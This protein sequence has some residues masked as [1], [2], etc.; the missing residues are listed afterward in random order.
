MRLFEARKHLVRRFSDVVGKPG[1]IA[2]IG[3]RSISVSVQGGVLEVFKVRTGAG[4]KMSGAELA[5]AF[6]LTTGM[7]LDTE[8]PVVASTTE[9]AV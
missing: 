5:K 1:E 2:A 8:T 7:K 6:S 3:E 9:A 4:Q